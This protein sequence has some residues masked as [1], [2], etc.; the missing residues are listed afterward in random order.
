MASFRKQIRSIARGKVLLFGIG[1]RMMADDGAGPLVV[2][3]VRER[4]SALACIDGGAAPENYLEKA[5]KAAPDTVLIVDAVSFDGRAGE[6]KIFRSSALSAGGISTHALSLAMVCEYLRNRLG[7]VTIALVG[8]Q[9]ETVTMGK[10]MSTAVQ[11]AVEDLAG[12]LVKEFA[13]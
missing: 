9:P 13:E 6:I 12:E 2:D 1:N 5:V 3:R 11:G 7:D 10:Q 4:R 8:I